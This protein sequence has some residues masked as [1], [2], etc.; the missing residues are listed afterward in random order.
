VP[1]YY[2]VFDVM[3]AGGRDTR[4]LPQ[5][6]RKELLASELR[7]GDPLRYTEHR[8][9]DGERLSEQACRDGWEGLIAKRADAFYRGGRS[10]DWLKFKCENAQ[11]FVIG[12]YTDPQRSRVG[13][14]ALLL[15]Y[16][17]S[18]GDLVYAGKVGTG[19]DN[20]L[21]RSLHDRLAGL[22]RHDS[23]FRRGRLPGRRGLHWVEPQLVGQV[24]FA[25][26]TDDG[27]LRHPRFQGLRDDKRP[28]DVVRELPVK[29]RSR[30]AETRASSPRRHRP[31]R[32]EQP[33]AGC[34][35]NHHKIL[36]IKICEAF[37]PGVQSLI[38]F[39]DPYGERRDGRERSEDHDRQPVREPGHRE[40]A[41]QRAAH[42]G[43]QCPGAALPV[44]WALA[45]GQRG[46]QAG[47]RA[48]S[49]VDRS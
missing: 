8:D 24:G 35:E 39:R 23:P 47:Q 29:D 26:W 21:L 41:Q 7:F 20:R 2:Y 9:R 5:R 49:R 18:D 4:S 46:H 15:G 42:D 10:R 13:F 14:G 38:A 12:G 31:G 30:I 25:E 33:Q 43:E 28:A 17:D 16:Y 19:F 22:E 1:V 48:G 44:L 45:A 34:E 32:S 6:E 36:Y 37:L 27:Q 40:R 11:E 3:Y